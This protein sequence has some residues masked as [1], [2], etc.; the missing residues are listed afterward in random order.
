MKRAKI[1][2]ISCLCATALIAIGLISAAV[3]AQEKEREKSAQKIEGNIIIGPSPGVPLPPGIEIGVPGQVERGLISQVYG[4][5]AAFGW[6]Q[7]GNQ[8]VQFLSA[9]MAFDNKI[10]KGAP[11]SGELVYESIQTLAD[12]NRIINRSTTAIYRDSQGRTRREQEFKFLGAYGAG[13]TQRRSI[14]ILDPVLEHQ[15]ILDPQTRIARE[16]MTRPRY[17]IQSGGV[18]KLG[19]DAIVYPPSNIS[20][21]VLQGGAIKKVQPDYPQIARAAKASGAVQVDITVDENGNV[22]AAEASSGHPLLREPAIEAAKQWQFKPTEVDGKAVKVKGQLTFNFALT[23]KKEDINTFTGSVAAA[24]YASAKRMNM[25]SRT[26]ELGK[27]N[28]EG[29]EA[30]G[31]R[32]INTI[33]AGTIGNE[34]PIEVVYERWYSP[35]LQMIIMTRSVDPRMGETTQRLVNINRSE[36]DPSLF[37]VPSDF[38]IEATPAPN[39]MDI[40]K[41]LELK[42]RKPDNQ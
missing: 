28:I 19:P 32:T 37:Q 15:Y 25:E 27:Q 30:E 10:V 16:F 13:D 38:T 23:D 21:G 40:Q 14:Q 34:R 17:S 36:P 3:T 2:S 31:T 20:G 11:F 1:A 12:G 22:I 26:E 8:T 42:R 4:S 41:V 24:P 18:P 39:A 5:S 35:E 7:D 33:P 9:E 6:V 29:I